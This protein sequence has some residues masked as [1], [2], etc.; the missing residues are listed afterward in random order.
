[1]LCLHKSAKFQSH[2]SKLKEY[3]SKL[4]EYRREAGRVQK[5]SCSSTEEY[6]KSACEDL[7]HNMKTSCVQ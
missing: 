6:K 7:K 3:R 4:E 5:M 1:V 2:S